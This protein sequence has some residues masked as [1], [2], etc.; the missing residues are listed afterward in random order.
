VLYQVSPN[1]TTDLKKAR[2]DL[3]IGFVREHKEFPLDRKLETALLPSD[4][5]W[6]LVTDLC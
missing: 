4:S 3:V 6:G 5:D 1:D 2:S